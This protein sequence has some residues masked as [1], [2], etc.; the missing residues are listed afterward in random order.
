MT[1]KSMMGKIQWH[2]TLAGS[3]VQVVGE[4]V[5]AQGYNILF[6][7]AGGRCVFCCFLLALI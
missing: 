5:C 3:Q 7:W 1:L 2:K 4:E 6:V